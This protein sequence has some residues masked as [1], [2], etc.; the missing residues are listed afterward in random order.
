VEKESQL[1][2]KKKKKKTAVCKKGDTKRRNYRGKKTKTNKQHPVS[3]SSS[4]SSSSLSSA[5]I[6]ISTIYSLPIHLYIPLPPPS[7]PPSHQAKTAL[8]K[9]QIQTPPPS[10]RLYTIVSLVHTA[11]FIHWHDMTREE[12]NVANDVHYAA[13]QVM[14][15]ALPFLSVSLL[16]LFFFAFFFSLC[17]CGSFLARPHPLS[18]SSSSFPLSCPSQKP[19]LQ[20]HCPH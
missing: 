16:F 2:R 10:S 15:Q 8:E 3:S 17:S 12:T 14:N 7:L 5:F 13:K 4:S 6:A 1:S 9:I 18:S 11:S 19:F 20:T